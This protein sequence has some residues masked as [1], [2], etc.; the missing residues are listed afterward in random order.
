M[1]SLGSRLRISVSEFRFP[2]NCLMY[3]HHSGVQVSNGLVFFLF[4]YLGKEG[5]QVEV[6]Q[7]EEP[8][9]MMF[10]F[11]SR[12][13]KKKIYI[14]VQWPEDVQIRILATGLEFL[15]KSQGKPQPNSFVY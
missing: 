6:V 9:S 2:G 12:E 7:V 5:Y 13:G 4:T 14:Q 15:G 8:E 10:G 3:T 1:D 11:A